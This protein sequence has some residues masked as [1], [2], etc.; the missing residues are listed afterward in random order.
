MSRYYVDKFLYEVDRD[1]DLLA[2][3]KSDP[4][5]LVDRW[6]KNDGHVLGIGHSCEQTSWLSFTEEERRA[7][8]DHDYVALFEMGAHCFLTLTI[9]IALYDEDYARTG[10]PLAF[11][12]EYA[13][14]LVHWTGKTYPS[15][16][17]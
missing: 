8:I 13:R 4:Q 14:K 6:D 7:L 15:V 1:P 2:Q 11:Q 10:G 9:F 5:G 3:Y 16:A 12:H 17:L